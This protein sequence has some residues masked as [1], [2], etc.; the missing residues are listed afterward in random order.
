MHVLLCASVS[1]IRQQS[2]LVTA[3]PKALRS[4]MALCAVK[5]LDQDRFC[6]ACGRPD[7]CCCTFCISLNYHKSD[8]IRWDAKIG[9]H[10]V[11]SHHSGAPP[12]Y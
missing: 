3:T 1:Y 5:V 10:H 11:E 12:E 8:Q 6:T 2:T 4:R 7:M 9:Q